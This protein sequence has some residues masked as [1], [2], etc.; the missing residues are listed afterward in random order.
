MTLNQRAVNATGFRWLPGMAAHFPHD[1]DRRVRV[2][3]PDA[4]GSTTAVPDLT[5][6]A[7][8]GCLLALVR[9]HF[10]GCHAE[11]N[12]APECDIDDESERAHWWAVYACNPHR[13]VSTGASEA[14]A[15]IAALECAP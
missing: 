9:E 11:P 3:I 12:G 2:S 14:E 13:R 5:D 8:L 4:W 1:N 10:P 7:T 6:P 15:L